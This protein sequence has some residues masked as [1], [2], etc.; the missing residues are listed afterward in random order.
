MKE[1]EEF[2]DEFMKN[3][4]NM[5]K[6]QGINIANPETYNFNEDIVQKAFSLEKNIVSTQTG[7]IIKKLPQ[8][9]DELER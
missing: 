4:E 2:M 8:K 7:E 3:I 5:K 6:Y 9:D 1:A